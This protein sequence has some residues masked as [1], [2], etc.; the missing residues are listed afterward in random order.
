MDQIEGRDN[1]I[2][3]LNKQGKKLEMEEEE[4]Q[5]A[6]EKTE[7]AI[8]LEENQA[9]G[10]QWEFDEIRQEVG[11]RN[12]KK[13]GELGGIQESQTTTMGA[14]GINVGLEQGT[15]AEAY[16]IEKKLEGN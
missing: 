4:L 8:R 13:K 2:Y 6:M 9:R 16:G 14:M 12:T 15:K 3:D 1:S 5:T 7:Y 10:Y 11:K